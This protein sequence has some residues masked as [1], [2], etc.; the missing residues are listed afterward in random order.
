MIGLM[1]DYGVGITQDEEV[2]KG[3]YGKS[4]D[5]GQQLGCD[6]YRELNEEGY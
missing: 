3:W 6:R 4:C 2:A 1:Y 5:N